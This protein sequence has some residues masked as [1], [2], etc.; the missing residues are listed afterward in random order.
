MA[1]GAGSR[2]FSQVSAVTN[3]ATPTTSTATSA[4]TPLDDVG[5]AV[6]IGLADV[7]HTFDD[8]D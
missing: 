7:Q 2:K 5:E 6:G 3:A 4:A 8:D 1:G